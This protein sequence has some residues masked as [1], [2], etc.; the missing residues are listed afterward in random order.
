[1]TTGFVPSRKL[2]NHGVS[3]PQAGSLECRL[4]VSHLQ[5]IS[6]NNRLEVPSFLFCGQILH[7]LQCKIKTS[8]CRH[9][10][11]AAHT[12]AEHLRVTFNCKLCRG[13]EA[14][15]PH[16]SRKRSP[17]VP[18][19]S[20]ESTRSEPSRAE[21]CWVQ[22]RDCTS[23]NPRIT[24]Q[25]ETQGWGSNS[26]LSVTWNSAMSSYKNTISKLQENTGKSNQ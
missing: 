26:E 18:W 11:Q 25:S 10:P 9:Q 21:W 2:N 16:P 3:G 23:K 20:R 4:W 1:M 15:G 14:Q 8:S 6:K 22:G 19:A 24:G 5:E 13:R 7:L 17:R 12:S